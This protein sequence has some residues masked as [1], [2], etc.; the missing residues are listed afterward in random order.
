P[1][2]PPPGGRV[3][4]VATAAALT[5]ALS[6]ARAGD[7][8][9]LA[10]GT[11]AGRFRLVGKRGTAQAPITVRGS[12]R[13]VLDGGEVSTGY[14]FELRDVAYVRLVGFAVT[15]S[16]KAVVTERATFSELDGLHLHH[17]GDE[18]VALRRDSTDNV[19]RNSL[20]EETGLF[21]PQYGEGVYIGTWNGSWQGGQPDASDRNQVL[22]NTFGPNVRAEHVDIK[23]GTSGG[24]VRGNRFE[25]RGLSGQNFADSFIDAQGNDYVISDNVGSFTAGS[26]TFANAFETHIQLDGWGCGNVFRGNSADLGGVGQYLVRVQLPN[27]AGNPNVVA[28]SNTVTGARTGLTNIPV[29]S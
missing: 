13:A 25:G 11:Y 27:C 15:R 14:G 19:V 23:E 29:T 18:A 1:N 12:R 22:D 26:G 28:S 2:P 4:N 8:I 20:I 21:E 10:D 16:Q 17:I 7:T 3:V 24:V 6:D 9:Q 5:A